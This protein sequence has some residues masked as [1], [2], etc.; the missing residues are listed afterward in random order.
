MSNFQKTLAAV[1]DV[2]KDCQMDHL[3]IG[4]AAVNYY[5]YTRLTIDLEEGVLRPLTQKYASE[6]IFQQ[7]RSLIQARSV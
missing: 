5:G 2:L 3:L 6:E 4:G 7:I 1:L